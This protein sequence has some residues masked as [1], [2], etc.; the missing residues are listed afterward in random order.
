[1]NQIQHLRAVAEELLLLE[2]TLRQLALWSN[3]APSAEALAS[4]APF[5]VDTLSFEA[6]LQWVFLPRMQQIL[7]ADLPLPQASALK[8]MAEIRY[9]DELQRVR[10]LL[11]SLARLDDLICCQ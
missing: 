6:W 2:Q 1:M 10:P 4:T 5:C 9:A 11:L 7:E 3:V 8:P